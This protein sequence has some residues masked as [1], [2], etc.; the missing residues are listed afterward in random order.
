MARE[1][2]I[3]VEGLR[4]YR[5]LGGYFT[6]DGKR[7]VK[8]RHIYRADNVGDATDV[9]KKTLV[10]ELGIKY[11]IDFRGP[12]ERDQAPYSCAGALYFPIPIDACSY[13]DEVLRMSV[14]DGR[15]AEALLRRVATTFLIDFKDAYRTF[16]H[17][18]LTEVKGKPAVFHCTAGKDRTGVAAALLLTALDVPAETIMEDFLLTNQFCTPPPCE[19]LHLGNCTIARD[20][21]E[22]LYRAQAFFLELSFG[23][24]RKRYGTVK[25][26]ME[27]ELGVGA[28]E[29]KKLRTYYVRSSS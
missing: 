19:S 21:I 3:A 20:A 24:V 14:L 29:L 8:Y 7:V 12:H 2:V 16:F 11:I 23:E 17:V 25:A 18:L 1:R 4:N 15:S 13:R 27:E 5:D 28:R 26:Y 22:V 9:G 6:Q 10:E